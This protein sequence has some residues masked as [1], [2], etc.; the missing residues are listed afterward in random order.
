MT[1]KA[2]YRPSRPVYLHTVLVITVVRCVETSRSEGEEEGRRSESPPCP[3][4]SLA[5]HNGAARSGTA[6]FIDGPLPARGQAAAKGLCEE[7]RRGL[8]HHLDVEFMA[9]LD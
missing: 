1:H 4:P 6:S 2:I 8:N 5:A 3:R 7:Q 9:S